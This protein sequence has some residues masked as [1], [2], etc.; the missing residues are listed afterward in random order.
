[1]GFSYFELSIKTC[2]SLNVIL[3]SVV[4]AVRILINFSVYG[5]FRVIKLDDISRARHVGAEA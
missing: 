3:I 5:V 1:M 4:V 2:G